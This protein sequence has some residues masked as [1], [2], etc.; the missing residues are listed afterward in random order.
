MRNEKRNVINPL[1]GLDRQHLT[2]QQN[3][4]RRWRDGDIDF[5]NVQWRVVA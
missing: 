2:N 1:D 4:S 5:A 3:K